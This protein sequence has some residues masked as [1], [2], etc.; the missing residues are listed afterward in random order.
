MEYPESCEEGGEE[1]EDNGVPPVTLGQDA[2][3]RGHPIGEG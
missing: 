1:K 3:E 2:R